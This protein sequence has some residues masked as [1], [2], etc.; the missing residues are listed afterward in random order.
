MRRN[1][2]FQGMPRLYDSLLMPPTDT[3]FSELNAAREIIKDLREG[4]SIFQIAA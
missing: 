3:G 4:F 1:R 2:T